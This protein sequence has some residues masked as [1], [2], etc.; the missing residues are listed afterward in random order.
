M[1]NTPMTDRHTAHEHDGHSCKDLLEWLSDY[2]DGDLK[3]ELYER[4]KAHANHCEPCVAFIQTLQKTSELIQNKPGIDVPP[5]AMDELTTSLQQCK[6]E[7]K[8]A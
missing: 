3:G 1:Q 4:I 6:N 2:I 8:S 5:E 7:M